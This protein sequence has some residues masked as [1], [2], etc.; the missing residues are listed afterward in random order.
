MSRISPSMAKNAIRRSLRSI[1]DPELTKTEKKDIWDHFQNKCAY[2]NR[3]MKRTERDGHIDHLVATKN[4]GT[5][6]ISNRVLSCPSCNGDDKRDEDWKLFLN[7]TVLDDKTKE[8]RFQQIN[9][10][11]EKHQHKQKTI[12]ENTLEIHLAEVFKA[13]DNAVASLRNGI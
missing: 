7:R 4:S 11:I 9:T 8:E 3:E 6:H 10:W 1:I 12:D 5:N 13:F 2:C